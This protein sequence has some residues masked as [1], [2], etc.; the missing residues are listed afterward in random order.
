MAER[1][2]S[3]SVSQPVAEEKAI[4]QVRFVARYQFGTLSNWLAKLFTEANALDRLTG[5]IIELPIVTEHG[6]TNTFGL[7]GSR[8][9][10]TNDATGQLDR[11]LASSMLIDDGG[12][13]ASQ[14][15]KAQASALASNDIHAGLP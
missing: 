12:D 3:E 10:T 11:F 4:S 6:A 13:D 2:K 8:T 5:L 7:E 15:V 14:V 9:L 1:T